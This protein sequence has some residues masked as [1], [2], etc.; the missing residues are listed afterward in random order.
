MSTWQAGGTSRSL[1]H[2][3]RPPESPTSLIFGIDVNMAGVGV[4]DGAVGDKEV[5]GDY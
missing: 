5:I 3:E 2:F 4:V 1:A